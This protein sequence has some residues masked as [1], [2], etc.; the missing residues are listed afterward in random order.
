M[1]EQWVKTESI[2]KVAT[3]FGS[4]QMIITQILRATAIIE[5]D[6]LITRQN[7][8][9]ANLPSAGYFKQGTGTFMNK[10]AIIFLL[11]ALGIAAQAR[12]IN[13]VQ[14]SGFESVSHTAHLPDD[15]ELKGAAF[16]GR[17]GDGMDFASDGIIFPGAAENGGAVSQV[18]L[19]IDQSKG[20]W[21]TF[22]F[23]GRAENGF[24][25]PDDSL[26][27]KIE[28]YSKK[29]TDYLDCA[30]SR[31]YGEILTDRKNLTVNGDFHRDGAAVWRSYE[32][33]ELIPFPEV[34][35]VRISVSYAK[36]A[37]TSPHHAAFLLDDF[38]LVQRSGSMTGK[39]DPAVARAGLKASPLV[40]ES[41]LVPLGGR[42]YYEPAPGETVHAASTPLTVTEEN[43]DRL[44]YKSDRYINPFLNNMTAW[45]RAGYKDED[46]NL[47]TKDRFVPD[48]VILIFKGDGFLT[49]KAKNLPNHPTARFPGFNPNYIQEENNTY[50]LPLEPVLDPQAVAVDD[51]DRDH[52]LPMGPIG[53][54]VNGVVFFNPF[55]AQMTDAS[56]IMDSCCG[57]PSPDNQYHYHKYPICVNT[58]FV[59]KG[60]GPY[61]SAG[62]MAKDSTTHPLNAF[63][64][65]YDPV[66]GWHYHVT[67][68]KFPYLIG[69][70]F[71]K[72]EPANFKAHPGGPPPGGG[73]PP[74][75][76][77]PPPPPF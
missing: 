14:N 54:A 69:G 47:I 74:D 52:A 24:T 31:I 21:L 38:S 3:P 51:S 44:F 58:P 9:L 42:W 8:F 70:Y 57:H 18:V 29:G 28:F 59:D 19:G 72:A 75:D 67:P 2:P 7:P 64:A 25:I 1:V 43:A 40:D 65:C 76:G 73:P 68:G 20:R 63:N 45:L 32:L 34:D 13:L 48:N 77:G 17:L 60:D 6:G 71:A 11:G 50:R 23:R 15:Y 36:G 35:A 16:W 55:D 61:Q 12:E 41:K 33:E 5:T 39:V 46:G 53:I 10:L 56:N 22:R 62:V 66:R 37:A 30:S 27:M 49:V 26:E 4:A